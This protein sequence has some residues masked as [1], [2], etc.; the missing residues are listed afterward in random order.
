LSKGKPVPPGATLAGFRLLSFGVPT[1]RDVAIQPFWVHIVKDHDQVTPEESQAAGKIEQDI[2]VW[3]TTLGPSGVA[4]GSAAH[5]NQLRDDLAR[6]VKAGW[7]VDQA[8]AQNL[9]AQLASARQ[10]LDARDL[11][12]ASS[13]LQALLGTVA[14]VS[15]GQITREGLGLVSL[16]VQSLVG[17]MK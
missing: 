16:N 15:P 7:V 3:S 11:A 4:H 13:R 12:G 5:W 2:I 6:A 14:R 8:L 9:A 17:N 10:A 1:V